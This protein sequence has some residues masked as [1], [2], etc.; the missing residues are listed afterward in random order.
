MSI[1]DR[2]NRT[3]TYVAGDWTGDAD[4]INQLM[5]WNK[6]NKWSLHFTDVHSLTQSYDGSLNCSIKSSLRKRMDISKKFV[7]IV[8]S[9]TK[10][11]QSGACFKCVWY[12]APK[13][14][15]EFASCTRGHL[16]VDNRSY[17]DFECALAKNDF[18]KKELD[19]VVLYNSMNVNPNWCPEPLRSIGTH[20]QMKKKVIDVNGFIH[21][22]WDYESVRKALEG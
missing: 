7:L 6:G 17:I 12:K 21:Y 8:G 5:T 19:V 2:V 4:A 18:D 16:F 1:E 14:V 22:D 11:L 3:C 15:F 10:D 20:A 9:K 13:S